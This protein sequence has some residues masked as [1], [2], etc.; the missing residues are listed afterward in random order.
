MLSSE[1]FG[2]F[3]IGSSS[4]HKLSGIANEEGSHQVM[5][6]TLH[7]GIIKYTKATRARIRI[8]RKF[9]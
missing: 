5:G 4:G 2:A 7:F 9:M 3:D 6:M 8:R 1:A